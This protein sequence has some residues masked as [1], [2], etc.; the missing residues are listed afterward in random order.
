[1]KLKIFNSVGL[2]MTRLYKFN[3]LFRIQF[4]NFNKK[5]SVS[6]FNSNKLPKPIAPYSIA[7]LIDMKDQLM[8]VT[9]GIIGLDNNSNLIS[10]D[11][12]EQTLRCLDILK[13]I[14]DENKGT[15]DDVVKV[16]LYV[17]NLDDFSKVNA[18]YEKVFTNNYPARTCVQVSRLPKNAVVELEATII[19]KK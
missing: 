15:L 1:M 18:V 16:N 10:D 11:I 9:S 14:I 8:I 4:Y 3:Q 19:V 17:T 5:M 2:N 12:E 6:R 13:T 7:T